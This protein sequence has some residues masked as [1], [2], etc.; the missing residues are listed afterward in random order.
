MK[1][2]LYGGFC[3]IFEEVAK[4]TLVVTEYPLSTQSHASQFYALYVLETN[5]VGLLEYQEKCDDLKGSQDPRA[6]RWAM[7]R[8]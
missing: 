8:L 7:E 1:K 4:G 5:G 3:I 2:I 6:K